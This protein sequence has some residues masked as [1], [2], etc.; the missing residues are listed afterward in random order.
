MPCR[1]SRA[2]EFLDLAMDNGELET[3]TKHTER[4]M[5]GGSQLLN[6]VDRNPRVSGLL[7]YLVES[8]A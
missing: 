6:P 8:G 7:L 2:A 3:L 5:C 1:V 4:D